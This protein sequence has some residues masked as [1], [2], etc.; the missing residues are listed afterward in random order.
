MNQS[1]TSNSAL[2]WLKPL[3]SL[4]LALSLSSS[5][6]AGGSSH[7]K[8]KGNKQ[9]ELLFET[10]K[11]CHGPDGEGN[12]MIQA[13]PIAGLPEWYLISTLN[14]FKH[15]V[16]GAHADDRTGLQMRPMARQLIK[17]G[18]VEAVAKAAAALPLTKPKHTLNGDATLGKAGYM[19]CQACHGAKAEGNVAMK[20]PPL[21][22]LPDWYIV[23]QL[24]KFKS[25]IRGTHPKDVE[26]KQMRP[27]AQGLADR[28]AMS[29]VAAYI[30]TLGSDTKAQH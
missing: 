16:R 8:A 7:G 30:A 19:L 12:P 27:M 28:K 23:S 25:G 26:G 6:W 24:E 2:Q 11:A 14:K 22:N 4:A 18:E 3:G 13:P 5:V 9:G 10:C 1:N 29:D 15:G 21:A 17:E 20:A